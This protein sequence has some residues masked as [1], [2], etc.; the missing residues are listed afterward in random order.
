MAEPETQDA[1]SAC[2]W[3][4]D[5]QRRCHYVSSV[6]LF[7][8]ADVRGV[9]SL[10]SDFI[11]KER[12]ADPPT[13]EVMNTNYLKT[14][15]TIPIPGVAKD[16]TDGRKRHFIL[17]DRIEG[18]DLQSAWPNLSQDAKVRIAEQTAACI[19]QLRKLQ[20]GKM[21]SLGEASIYSGWLFL[22]GSGT[23][24]GP[25]GSDEELWQSLLVKPEKLP[26]K[27]RNA[28]RKRLP[29]RTPYTFTHGDL[30]TVNII[31]KDD[32]LAAI[33]DWESA[34]YFLFGGSLLQLAL[35]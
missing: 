29:P 1:C 13:F 20:S 22:Q 32:N 15:T 25:F 31:V 14:R 5:Q 17:M 27:A 6:K 19:Q 4:T 34:G 7:Y 18:E 33:V 26:E 11:L 2:G 21:A 3:T 8:G 28:F 24:H 10:G 9:W 16:W 12:P 35:G 30:T 23:P